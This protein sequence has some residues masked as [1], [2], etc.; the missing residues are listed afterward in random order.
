MAGDRIVVFGDVI[1]DIVVVP[2]GP[3][4]VDTDTPSSIVNR[5]GGSAANMAAW[6]GFAGA[7]VDFV[8]LVGQGDVE[9]HSAALAVVG[10]TPH[11]A[12]HPTLPTGA[13]IVLVD[14]QNRSMLTDRG[15]NVALGPDDV[16]DELLDSAAIIHFSGYSIFSGRDPEEFRRLFERARSR[17]VQV[18]VDPGSAGFL[19]DFGTAEFLRVIEG[20]S[21]FL[22]NL[23]EGRVLT[24]LHDA[25]EIAAALGRR[26]DLVAVTLGTAGVTVASRGKDCFHVHAVEQCIVDPTGAGDAFS[27]GFLES[28][29]R[30]HDPHRAADAGV[31]LAARAVSMTGGRPAS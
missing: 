23:E 25:R 27:A 16:P 31:S 22:P 26:F 20:A 10:V 2:N 17:G 29:L 13:I 8:G 21:I 1:D 19:N 12:A 30:L 18:S 11:L 15:A 4:R 5:A 9:R 6:A 28:W 3:I 14:G 7:Q 24:G